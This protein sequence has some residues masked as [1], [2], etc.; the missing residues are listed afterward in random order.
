VQRLLPLTWAHSPKLPSITP[1][2]AKQKALLEFLEF[3]LP[4]GR[5]SG[6]GRPATAPTVDLMQ[7]PFTVTIV[8]EGCATGITP[9]V[10]RGLAIGT[11]ASGALW[12]LNNPLHWLSW[13]GLR[14]ASRGIEHCCSSRRQ[15]QEAYP[16]PNWLIWLRNCLVL[17][18][19]LALDPVSADERKS[20]RC[21]AAPPKNVGFLS[22]ET[23]KPKPRARAIF[24]SARPSC[25]AA[26]DAHGPDQ[27]AHGSYRVHLG[28][29][30]AGA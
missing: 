15:D 11:T 9:G 29:V 24:Y 18:P 28:N 25:T 27:L 20:G 21:V 2:L 7:R 23:F 30:Y 8:T 22:G 14:W 13:L 1:G 16:S 4:A 10:Q 17:P 12:H 26:S 6:A 3:A 5:A 19:A